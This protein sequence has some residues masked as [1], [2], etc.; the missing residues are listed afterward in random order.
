MDR[1]IDKRAVFVGCARNC[2]VA[3]PHVLD[4]ILSMSRLFLESAFIFVENDSQD[5]TQTNLRRW[6]DGGRNARLIVLDGLADFCSIRT[7]RLEIARNRYLSLVRSEYSSYDFLFVVDCDEVNAARIDLGAVRRAINFLTE[8]ENRAAVFANAKGIYYDL[9]ALRHRLRCPGDIWEEACDYAIAH[10]VT[11]EEA[12]RETFSKRIITIAPDQAMPMEVDSAF[13]GLGIYKIPSIMRNGKRHVGYNV[14]HIPAG[15]IG[16]RQDGMRA[17]G[18][19]CCEHV[20][21]NAGFRERG[22]KLF[23]LPYLINFETEGLIFP[24][25]GWR[26]LLFDLRLLPS[27]P[28]EIGSPS[29][30]RNVGRNKQCPCGSG[31]RFKHCH[32]AF[33]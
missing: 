8:E 25:S 14:K 27:G 15:V 11:D 4:N 28:F 9:W 13:G 10:E 31:K 3:L 26:G 21:F 33:T 5:A 32:G 20:S 6:C 12:F 18:W 23:V 1:I 24:P 29:H 22:D 2:A 30:W 19:Q 16:L 17:C 7:L